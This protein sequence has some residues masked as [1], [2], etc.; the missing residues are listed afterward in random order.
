M[1]HTQRSQSHVAFLQ[2]HRGMK[3]IHVRR[4]LVKGKELATSHAGTADRLLHQCRAR[5]RQRVWDAP[6]TIFFHHLHRTTGEKTCEQ[7]HG[8]FQAIALG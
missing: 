7:C 2:S 1:R 3:T 8:D 4:D 5:R 6:L